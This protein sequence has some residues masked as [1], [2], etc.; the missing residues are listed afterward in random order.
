[1]GTSR[2]AAVSKSAR[3]AAQRAGERDG[4][5]V[6]CR[7]QRLPELDRRR[8]AAPG[9]TRP[10][11]PRPGRRAHCL[12]GD[13]GRGRVGRV[14]LE[15]TGQPA[16]KADAVSPPA[17]LKA[18]G[19]FDAEKTAT[20]PSG[21]ATRRWSG[22]GGAASGRAVSMIASA[23]RPSRGAAAKARSWATVRATSPAQALRRE[24]R[25][26]PGDARRGRRSP[27]SRPAATASR[28][29]ASSNAP[30]A[31]G[32]G[33]RRKASA[34]AAA[35]ARASCRAGLGDAGPDPAAGP[36]VDPGEHRHVRWV[37]R[38]ASRSWSC[39]PVAE[40]TPSVRRVTR[41]GSDRAG[42]SRR[43]HARGGGCAASG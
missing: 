27:S 36:G 12:P 28:R 38:V 19:K 33:R 39:A 30:G 11:R 43:R 42:S 40:V 7:R 21:A 31:P 20:G 26:R 23:S 14:R 3:P 2:R 4:G 24:A 1:M 37:R 34:A 32:P 6:R 29:T 35:A 15:D 22:R 10:A 5:D 25:L 8:R 17:V 16:A 18:N 41:A 9:T 13:A